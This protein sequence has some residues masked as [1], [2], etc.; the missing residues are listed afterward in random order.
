MVQ[1]VHI[2]HTVEYSFR[3][4]NPPLGFLVTLTFHHWLLLATPRS[5]SGDFFPSSKL[6]DIFPNLTGGRSMLVWL[7]A[8]PTKDGLLAV[9]GAQRTV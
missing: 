6:T 8:T 9:F 1:C 7:E 2:A 3:Q 4:S 5:N